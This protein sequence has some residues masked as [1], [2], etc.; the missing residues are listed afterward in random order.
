VLEA[1]GRIAPPPAEAPAPAAQGRGAAITPPRACRPAGWVEYGAP[2]EFMTNGSTPAGVAGLP[3]LGPPWSQL[4]A[5]D[6]NT[7]DTLWQMPHGSVTALGDAGKGIGSIAPRG[8]VVVTVG[9][10]VLAGSSSDRRI[11]A[12]VQ[13]NG[14]VLWDHE[15]AG[16]QEGVPAV[17]QVSGRQYIAVAVEGN[18]VFQPRPSVW[19]PIPPAVPGQYAVFALPQR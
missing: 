19:N 3:I 8:G 2:Y 4:T 7:G 9:G 1:Q 10:F 16:P 14:R 12:C 15:L 5:C 6:L 18:G 13:D 11:R 17:C